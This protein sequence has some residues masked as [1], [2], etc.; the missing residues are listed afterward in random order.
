MQNMLIIVL[1]LLNVLR[2]KKGIF[3]H[4]PLTAGTVAQIALCIAAAFFAGT[5]ERKAPEAFAAIH[6]RT[7][8]FRMIVG[9]KIIVKDPM[10]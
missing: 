4:R 2:P 10:G 1:G 6:H 7:R 8:R 5:T 3:F 9:I